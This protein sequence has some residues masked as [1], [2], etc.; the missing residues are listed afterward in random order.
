MFAQEF[1]DCGVASSV[2]GFVTT[3]LEESLGP[4]FRLAHGHLQVLA[5]VSAAIVAKFAFCRMIC[6]NF[7]FQ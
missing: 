2:D 1:F 4:R 5:P 3:S 6:F 7:A